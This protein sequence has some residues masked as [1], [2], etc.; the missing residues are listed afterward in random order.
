MTDKGNL[1][2]G[3]GQ[4]DDMNSAKFSSMKG[5]RLEIMKFEEDKSTE[6]SSSL[7]SS[8]FEVMPELLKKASKLQV[9]CDANTLKEVQRVFATSSVLYIV[10]SYLT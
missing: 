4:L 10:L 8:P 3:I 2:K 6:C 7:A 9:V 5:Q 1:P